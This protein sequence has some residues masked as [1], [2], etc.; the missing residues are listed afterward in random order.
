MGTFPILVTTAII[1]LVMFLAV[2]ASIYDCVSHSKYQKLGLIL[3]ALVIPIFGPIYV[4]YL[5]KRIAVGGSF[6]INPSS[7]DSF[8]DSGSDTSCGSSDSGGGSCD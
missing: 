1:H 2:S 8:D 4:N 6:F 7:H 3:I 5:L